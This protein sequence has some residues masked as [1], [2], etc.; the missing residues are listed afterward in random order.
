MNPP[1]S[2][3]T[4]LRRWFG[5][6]AFRGPQQEVIEAIGQAGR[7]AGHALVV[8]PTGSGKS[9]CYQIPA[10]A[11]VPPE[12]QPFDPWLDRRL[13]VVLSP[14]I[15]LMKDQTD[16]LQGRGI[17]AA[18]INSSLDRETREQRYRELAGG[19]FRLLYVTPERFRKAA[20]REAIQQREVILLAVDEAH[21]VSEWGHDFRPDYSRLAEIRSLLGEPPTLALTATATPACQADILRQLGLS[22]ADVHRFH[23][24]IERPNLEL[25]VAE[26]GD[27]EAKL[28][29]IEAVAEDRRWA[30][31]SGI[32]YCTLIKTL[33]RISEGLRQRGIDHLVYHGELRRA[34]RRRIQERFMT[35]EIPLVVATGAFGMGIDKA[36]IRFVVHAEVPGSLEA[37][38]QEIGRAGRDGQPACCRLL[39]DPHDLMT[40]M[41]FIDWRNPDA[42]FFS[43]LWCYLRERSE[44]VAAFGLEWLN[45]QLQSVSRHD[46]R[47][48]TALGLLDRYGSVAGPRPPECFR[49]TATAD[50]PAVFR[51]AERLA[52]KKQR[53]QQRLYALVEY[54]HAEDRQAFLQR[55]FG[56]APA[57]AEVADRRGSTSRPNP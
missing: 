16:A 33:E 44:E 29:Q 7:Q 40:Q 26:V 37:Y 49:V 11:I 9:L 57:V 27:E 38:Y 4:V 47:L 12:V 10:L 22:A 24:G 52:E 8:M 46:H 39:Y 17:D 51:D 54:I 31:G 5:F 55:Y 32:V 19:H 43:R 36:A 42:D 20:F 15:A 21:C 45:A 13:V 41:Q 2:P 6:P 25:E 34:E 50:L 56:V 30:D 53:D 18:F 3:L 1:A 28:Q 14:L 35:G 23:S 48:E